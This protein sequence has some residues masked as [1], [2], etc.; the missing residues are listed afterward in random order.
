[1][2]GAHIHSLGPVLKIEIEALDKFSAAAKLVGERMEE[3]AKALGGNMA[4]YIKAPR[5]QAE[6]DAAVRDEI[7]KLHAHQKGALAT[8]VAED[9]AKVVEL[10]KGLKQSDIDALM[11]LVEKPVPK[12]ASYTFPKELFDWTPPSPS[13]ITNVSNGPSVAESVRAAREARTRALGTELGGKCDTSGAPIEGPK[14]L[15]GRKIRLD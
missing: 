5:T 14:N 8:A 4:K 6:I 7:K 9:K 12:P 13:K 11:D 3:F 2:P 15:R 10:L 1:M